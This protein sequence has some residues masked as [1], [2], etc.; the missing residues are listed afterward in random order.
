MYSDTIVAQATAS[1]IAALNLIRVSGTEAI[2]IVQSVFKGKNLTNVPSHSATYGHI[3]EGED[4]IDEVMVFVYR[5]PNSYTREDLV[6]I[7]CHGGFL[8]SSEI[9]RLLIKQGARPADRGEF[10]N[11]AYINGRIDLTEAESIMDIVNA[12]T[13]EQLLIAQKTL[14]GDTRKLVEEL[15]KDLLFIIAQIEVNIDYPEYDDVEQ[16]TGEIIIPRIES[17][18]ERI[19]SILSKA[20]T[21]RI[22]RD[23]I[24]TVI[25]GKP[26]V[27][28]SSL[29]NSLLKEE[30]AIVTEISGTTRDLIEA[31]MNL[32][33]ILLKLVDT[34]GIRETTDTIEKI[35]IDRTKAAMEDADLVLL[36]LDQS[37][38]LTEHDKALL[39]VTSD[40]TRIIVGNKTDLGKKLDLHTEKVINISAKNHIGIDSL[41]A[42]VKTLFLKSKFDSKDTLIAN[43]RHIARLEQTKQCLADSLESAKAK[44]PIDMIEIDLRDAWSYLGEI[45]GENSSDSLINALFANFCLGK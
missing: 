9:I 8:A 11:R 19:N 30:K 18:L 33:G 5:A 7:T 38:E 39:D 12:K 42:E 20:N 35:G 26:N 17:L 32:D 13:R 44:L 34:A 6:E 28:K 27:G 45:T 23:G 21:G 1:G 2:S 15:Q 36:V 37:A 22:I 14:Q 24:K 10:T 43:V 4:T 29:L 16:L 31:E 40:K 41:A 25:V 3:V